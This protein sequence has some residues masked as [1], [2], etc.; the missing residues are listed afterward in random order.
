VSAVR[1]QLLAREWAA[2]VPGGLRV[3]KP[4]AVLDAWAAADDWDKRTRTREYS[5]LVTDPEEIAARVHALLGE[6]R[7]AFTQWFAAALRHPHTTP[8]VTTVYVEQFPDEA[9][10][11]QALLARQ[12]DTGGRLRL[13]LPR[14]EGV[15]NPLQTVRGLPLVSDVQLYLDLIHA[16]LRGDEAAAELRKWPDFAGGW[17]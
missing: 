1:Q 15:L 11:E 4:G 14:D 5:L 16:G 17:T 6:K 8:P 2:E 13:V 12:V 9:Q 10:L 3:A 7:H